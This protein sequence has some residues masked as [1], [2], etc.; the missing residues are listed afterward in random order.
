MPC[1]PLYC[2][3]G[4]DA[5]LHSDGKASPEAAQPRSPRPAAAP[6]RR[7]RRA[8][9]AG[10]R[11]K[12]CCSP[13]ADISRRRGLPASF[14][15]RC[16]TS[17]RCHTPLPGAGLQPRRAARRGR[18]PWR[19]PAGTA[20][21]PPPAGSTRGERGHGGTGPGP[22]RSGAPA[23]GSASRGA[24]GP[25]GGRRERGLR[26]GAGAP[27]QGKGEAVARLGTHQECE[28]AEGR[29]A[30]FPPW[31]SSCSCG[32]WWV[33]RLLGGKLWFSL[34]LARTDQL[35]LLRR[36]MVKPGLCRAFAW[37]ALDRTAETSSLGFKIGRYRNS[38]KAGKKIASGCLVLMKIPYLACSLHLDQK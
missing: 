3:G 7:Q 15:A 4:S 37:E 23:A 9:R 33:L 38:H 8:R 28:K 19:V 25:L 24:P 35:L 32:G 34:A 18:R 16:I 27:G 26:G 17:R 36:L 21:A 22:S 12:G 30:V 1:S 31:G 5:P 10:R 11:R 6:G 20:P 29:D 2:K 14:F 13:R